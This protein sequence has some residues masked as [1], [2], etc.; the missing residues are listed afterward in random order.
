MGCVLGG[1]FY[2]CVAG[3]KIKTIQI[4][5]PVW[6]AIQLPTFLNADDGKLMVSIGINSAFKNSARGELNHFVYLKFNDV[7]S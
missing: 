3:S 1:V 7:I 4:C 6:S 2:L 5:V